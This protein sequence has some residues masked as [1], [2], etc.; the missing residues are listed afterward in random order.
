MP[1]YVNFLKAPRLAGN[2]IWSVISITNDLGEAVAD[3]IH[4][5]A[6]LLDWSSDESDE[7]GTGQKHRATR[8]Y[9]WKPGM[10]EL[11]IEIEFD[12]DMKIQ[13]D[14]DVSLIIHTKDCSYVGHEC[15]WD[16]SQ[17]KNDTLEEASG[18]EDE[19]WEDADDDSDEDEDRDTE[20][21]WKY[22]HQAV[23]PCLEH[24]ICQNALHP[25]I[26][27]QVSFEKEPEEYFQRSFTLQ[28]FVPLELSQPLG[29]TS[30][31]GHV[32]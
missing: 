11:K 1:S 32:W 27:A 17:S 23:L 7:D 24:S 20:G 15:G 31:C 26:G 3:E 29:V 30:L 4:F 18:P 8:E 5:F 10:Q 21:P 22:A 13:E 25:L 28:N 9:T 2:K 19:D 12:W 16:A 14:M 6:Q